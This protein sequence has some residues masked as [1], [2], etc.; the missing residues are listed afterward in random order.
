[1]E[2]LDQRLF[3]LQNIN[4]ISDR[5]YQLQ[6]DQILSL[7][8]LLHLPFEKN[9]FY[10]FLLKT[11]SKPD[12]ATFSKTLTSRFLAEFTVSGIDLNFFEFLIKLW[13]ISN[14]NEENSNTMEIPKKKIK[15]NTNIEQLKE[16]LKD[17]KNNMLIEPDLIQKLAKTIFTQNNQ[18]EARNESKPK[19]SNRFIIEN[20]KV[21]DI[22]KKTSE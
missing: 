13:E 7:S 10:D 22:K 21:E 6:L 9:L 5:K 3:F 18:G 11:A 20:P 17:K 12:S 1:M 8:R 19:N 16:K 14:E 2:N 15:L 4:F